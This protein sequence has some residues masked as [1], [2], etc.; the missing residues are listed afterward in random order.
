M[1]IFQEAIKLPQAIKFH[2]NLHSASQETTKHR[3]IPKHKLMTKLW[4]MTKHRL[5]M[6]PRDVLEH[7]EMSLST[8]VT[9]LQYR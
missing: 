5:I 3:L 7:L 6:A 4:L 2:E 9:F 1:L 8:S